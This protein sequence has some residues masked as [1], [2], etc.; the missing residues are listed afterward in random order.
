MLGPPTNPKHDNWVDPSVK[1]GG[2]TTVGAG[3]IIGAATLVAD[4]CS[5]KRSVVGHDCKIGSNAKVRSW[6]FAQ[7]CSP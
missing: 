4:K 1:L 5:I 7:S 2:K 3:C 6:D